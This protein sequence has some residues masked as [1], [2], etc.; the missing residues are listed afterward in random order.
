MKKGFTLAEVLITLGIIGVVAALTIPTLMNNMNKAD[1]QAKFKKA[2]A[3]INTVIN[4]IVYEK[5]TLDLQKEYCYH[6]D[7]TCETGEYTGMN[8]L[9]K[10]LTDMAPYFKSAVIRNTS[11]PIPDIDTRG[12]GHNI[13]GEN[14]GNLI[15]S[16]ASA[17]IYLADG[18]I[19]DINCPSAAYPQIIFDLNG[20]KGPNR[21]G[22][23]IFWWRLEG[24]KAVPLSW[25]YGDGQNCQLTSG[26]YSGVMCAQYAIQDKCPWDATKGYWQ[27]LP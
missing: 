10:L 3:L 19:I 11:Q 13:I 26:Q 2:N 16:S 9:D 18:S 20:N 17:A 21:F 5:Q 15:H 23:D 8:S 22:Y 12:N 7:P 4:Q 27:C 1:L 14:V 6:S 24:T 25:D